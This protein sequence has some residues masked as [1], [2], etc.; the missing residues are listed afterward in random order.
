MKRELISEEMLE[1]TGF[2]FRKL[3]I[4]WFDEAGDDQ[5]M[6]VRVGFNGRLGPV[7]LYLADKEKP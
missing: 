4:Q 2:D 1:D 6:L 7:P 5:I 3:L